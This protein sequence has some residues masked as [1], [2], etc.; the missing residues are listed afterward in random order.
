M[1]YGIFLL[2]STS[3]PQLDSRIVLFAIVADIL[4]VIDSFALLAFRWIPLTAVGAWIVAVQA[5][6]VLI[7]A[8]LQIIGALRR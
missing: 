6:I 8:I 7:F 5:G 4:W 2:F 1:F 3:R